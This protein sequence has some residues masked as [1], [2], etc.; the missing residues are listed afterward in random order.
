MSDTSLTPPDPVE[1]SGRDRIGE[2]ECLAKLRDSGA[3]TAHEF[4]V[5]KRAL[6]GPGR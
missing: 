6:L 4:E 2:L 3:L 1:G 5:E